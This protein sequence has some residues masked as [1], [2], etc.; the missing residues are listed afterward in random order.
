MKIQAVILLFTR[1]PEIHNLI[2]ERVNHST[3]RFQLVHF[4]EGGDLLDCLFAKPPDAV[5]QKGRPCLVMMDLHPPFQDELAI[6]HRIKND[7]VLCKLPVMV[8]SESSDPTMIRQ[9]YEMSCNFYLLKPSDS[10]ALPLFIDRVTD[11]L[12][13]E[14]IKLPMVHTNVAPIVASQSI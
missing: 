1:R 7:S 8:L 11:F 3:S 14:G 2:S 10:T 5:F 12:S 13:L 4:S 6:L 9:C